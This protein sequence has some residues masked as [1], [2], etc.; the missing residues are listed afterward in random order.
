MR[1]IGWDQ[2]GSFGRDMRQVGWGEAGHAAERARRS[3]R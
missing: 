2:T 3:S 1:R